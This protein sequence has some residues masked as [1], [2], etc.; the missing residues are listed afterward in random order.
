MPI[1]MRKRIYYLF[2]LCCCLSF[3]SCQKG[4]VGDDDSTVGSQNDKIKLELN[5]AKLGDADFE[6]TYQVSRST[7]VT[8]FCTR[9]SVAVYQNGNRVKQINQTSSDENFGKIELS[10]PAGKY[11]LVA[12]A[13]S[14]SKSATMTDPKKVTFSGGMSDT[15]WYCKELDLEENTSEDIYMKRVVAVFRLS[16]TDAVPENMKTVKFGFTGGSSTLD[17]IT[18][19]GCVN[20]RQSKEFSI[21]SDM[22]GKKADF[23][24]YTFPKPD[25]ET[26]KVTVTATDVNGNMVMQKVF[27]DVKIKSNMITTYTG[28]LFAGAG[29][30]ANANYSTHFLTD[31]EW[32][33]YDV[34]F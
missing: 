32:E 12:L 3:T 33:K 34:T 6:K 29:T 10:L 23:D 14:G 1:D 22:V 18:G 31:D 21:T 2:L 17:A 13:Y 27:E 15:F 16:T 4:Y 20:S 11:D 25:S 7:D 30:G 26:L 5:V 28:E 9:L 19:Q 24:V 8:T